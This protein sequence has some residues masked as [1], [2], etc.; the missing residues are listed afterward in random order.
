MINKPVIFFLKIF[1][2]ILI[3]V[4]I[5][6]FF[7]LNILK[8]DLI[9]IKP[10]VKNKSNFYTP[11]FYHEMPKEPL[12]YIRQINN[13]VKD[14]LYVPHVANYKNF[15]FNSEIIS[16]Y[17][18]HILKLIIKELNIDH[19]KINFKKYFSL[20]HVEIN[21]FNK[22]ILI[23]LFEK[24]F[25]KSEK[26]D[27]VDHL[28]FS[29]YFEY[30]WSNASSFTKYNSCKNKENKIYFSRLSFLFDC[31]DDSEKAQWISLGKKDLQY[32]YDFHKSRTVSFSNVYFNQVDTINLKLV[33]YLSI[34]LIIKLYFILFL[35]ANSIL[36][37]KYIVLN[38]KQ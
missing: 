8:E 20:S 13:L 15:D 7:L 33:L 30:I 34:F 26:K 28:L 22:Y 4:F 31:F 17:E 19:R 25:S 12:P 10:E 6:S 27:F 35:F 32:K 36:I 14:N 16:N 37:I 23:Y 21:F 38:K 1:T 24:K 18:D 9:L 29:K 5:L 2:S 11:F 3:V